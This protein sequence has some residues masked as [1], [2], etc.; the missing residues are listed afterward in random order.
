MTLLQP[1]MTRTYS[2]MERFHLLQNSSSHKARMIIG[3]K[4]WFIYK[5]W[6]IH[7]PPPHIHT[8]LSTNTHTPI[9]YTH[10]HSMLTCYDELF[11]SPDFQTA[12]LEP[13]SFWAVVSCP[14]WVLLLITCPEYHKRLVF[15]I[16]LL[17]VSAE[18]R[19]YA[20]R[21]LWGQTVKILFPNI[22]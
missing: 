17:F 11:W 18:Q 19:S 2:N 16:F 3:P 20:N 13:S 12:S 15:I 6:L 4:K 1:G 14:R 7:P 21:L 22:S 5:C 9:T 10:S 8:L